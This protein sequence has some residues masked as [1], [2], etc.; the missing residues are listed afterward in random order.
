MTTY[1]VA[2]IGSGPGGYVA[3][4]RAAQRGMKTVIIEKEH[5][6]GV[7]LNWGCIP[8]KVI[9]HS[10]NTLRE[11]RKASDLGI[12]V[13]GINFDMSRI[14]ARSRNVSERLSNG[15]T[16]LLKKHNITVING[17]AKLN[18]KNEIQ[19]ENKE[20][21]HIQTIKA[22]NII[23]ATG[24]QPKILPHLPIDG[25]DVIS[26]RHA[27]ERETLPLSMAIIGAGAIGVEFAYIY[28]HLGVEI[29]IIEA[30]DVLLPVEDAEIS[31][32]LLKQFKKQKIRCMLQ[33]KVQKISK[34]DKSIELT[35]EDPKGSSTLNVETVLSAIGVSP[36]TADIGLDTVG[37][38]Q[39]K[40]FIIVDK[41]Q[42]TN[43]AG[44]YAIGD[45]TGIPMLAHKASKEALISIDHIQGK[46]PKP[47][48]KMFIPG[49]T[50]CEPQ[51][52]SIG[53]REKDVVE[54]N[55]EYKVSKVYYRAIGKAQAV[56]HI[57]GFLKCIIDKKTRKIIG[58]HCI[59]A[60]ATELIAEL[61]VAITQGLQIDAL[62]ETIHAHPTLSEL[63]LE[64]AEN[65]LG[66]AIHV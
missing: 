21:E 42:Q 29:T 46:T 16:Y 3:A 57:D 6:G 23:I 4:I 14:I 17:Y 25:K 56:N 12:N 13:E 18:S 44:I 48:N 36:N 49:C 40:G 31:R 62:A 65:A 34:N 58:A 20:K 59:G 54:K 35:I 47:L 61:T 63:I 33:S 5:I 60:E 7:C 50:Y 43:I 30:L 37:I 8:T 27:L 11:I 1:N 28:K 22:K 55:I 19:V 51:I 9:I 45:V 32:E 26:S 64:T 39:E 2:I 52:A 15:V 53:L 24:S 38:K 10:V 41:Y 66:E